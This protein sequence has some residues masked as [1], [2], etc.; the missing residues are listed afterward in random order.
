MR[1]GLQSGQEKWAQP[2]LA[3]ELPDAGESDD[4]FWPLNDITSI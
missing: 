1:V 3:A 4:F 2:L